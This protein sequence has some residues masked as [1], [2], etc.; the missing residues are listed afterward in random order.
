VGSIFLVSS[1]VVEQILNYNV[2][3]HLLLTDK[4][5]VEES[6]KTPFLELKDVSESLRY[7][8]TLQVFDKVSRRI[9]SRKSSEYTKDNL[10]LEKAERF[11]ICRI[12]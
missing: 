6:R 10:L 9:I 2:G 5:Q 11:K 8:E 1:H 4:P 3:L 12:Y 7:A